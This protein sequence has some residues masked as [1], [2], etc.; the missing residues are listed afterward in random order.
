[1]LVIGI[2]QGCILV[3]PFRRKGLGS[4]AKAFPSCHIANA[5]TH[6]SLNAIPDS[7]HTKAKRHTQGKAPFKSLCFEKLKLHVESPSSIPRK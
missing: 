2:S 3:E 6:H 1:M 5:H 4:H 7:D